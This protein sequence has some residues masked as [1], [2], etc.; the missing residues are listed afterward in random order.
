M[1][2]DLEIKKLIHRL[3]GRPIAI[4]GLRIDSLLANPQA[5]FSFSDFNDAA[6]KKPAWRMEGSIAVFD[7]EGALWAGR[8]R[9]AFAQNN[10]Y[11]N[12]RENIEAALEDSSVEGILFNFDSPGGEASA[13]MWDLSDFIFESRGIKPIWSIANDSM[14]SAAYAIGSATSRIYSTITGG[15]GSVGVI[16]THL[17]FSKEDK[18][19]GWTYTIFSGGKWKADGNRHE[20]LSE[21]ARETI[22]G[23]VDRIYGM[24]VDLVSRNLKMSGEEIRKTEAGV[25]YGSNG[26]ASKFSDAVGN[27]EDAINDMKN[28]ISRKKGVIK[29]AGNNQDV[30]Q[31]QAVQT[32][33]Q[34]QA[35]QVQ[36]QGGQPQVQPQ[37]QVVAG[38]QVTSQGD[39]VSIQNG[40]GRALHWIQDGA[41]AFS[42]PVQEINPAQD[43]RAAA[44]QEAQ[45]EIQ[46]IKELCLLAQ[47]SVEQTMQYVTSGKSLGQ[48]RAELVEAR[49]QAS[50]STGE[51]NG[52][53]YVEPHPGAK[54]EE[55][56]DT[57][58]IWNH[59]KAFFEGNK[60]GNRVTGASA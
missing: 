36:D 33:V 12:L 3:S 49:V 40:G 32:Q 15:V 10:F 22:Q 13:G 52:R 7:I 6:K 53:H 44:R 5:F 47:C 35:V 37:A 57:D 17:E 30:M 8:T 60:F 55:P 51:I 28:L 54:H 25:Y 9:W 11:E 18:L 41:D 46:A 48:I 14:F 16:A 31:P 50:E 20:P 21:H 1:M 42:R 23:E 19:L 45:A 27:Y 39:T 34:P 4:D 29:M 2:E 43:Q 24:F 56:V 26:V 38:F 58:A 59:T